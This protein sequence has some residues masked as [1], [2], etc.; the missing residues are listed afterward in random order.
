VQHQ[1]ARTPV[2]SFASSNLIAGLLLKF[3]IF[4]HR[5]QIHQARF[6][7]NVL[8]GAQGKDVTYFA[9]P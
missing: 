8:H 1:D 3:L 5:I 2:I 6:Q 9:A 7:L 4:S